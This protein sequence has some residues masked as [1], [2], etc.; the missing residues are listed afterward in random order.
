MICMN[1]KTADQ[2]CDCILHMEQ[3]DRDIKQH[4]YVSQETKNWNQGFAKIT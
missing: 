4:P 2:T 1:V 3:K